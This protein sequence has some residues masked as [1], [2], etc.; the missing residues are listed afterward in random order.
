M[1]IFFTEGNSQVTITIKFR[2][3]KFKRYNYFKKIVNS[4]K[5]LSF[6]DY[7]SLQKN[8]DFIIANDISQKGVGFNADYNEVSI[9][10]QKGNVEKIK[11]SKKSFI[12]TVIAE[13]IIKKLL[14]D[15]KNFN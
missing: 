7:I 12:A 2:L 6:T 9:I 10:D 14:V 15:D 11:K 5:Q 13:K 4:L 8:S 3:K 1:Q